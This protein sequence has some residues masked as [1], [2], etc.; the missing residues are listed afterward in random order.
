M[1]L[2]GQ[3]G[4]EHVAFTVPDLE[5]AVQFFVN[6]LG[7]EH[8][9]DIGPFR[10]PD[11][12]WFSDNLNLDPRAEIPR[13]C[14]LRCGNGSNFELFEYEAPEQRQSWPQMSDWGGFHLA[15]YVDDMDAALTYLSDE[16]VRILGGAKPGMGVEAGEK[17]TFAHFLTPWGQLLE[18]VSFP[19]GKQY[20]EGRDRLLWHPI[21][22]EVTP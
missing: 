17:S 19:N 3:R 13:A 5:E 6:V 8:F 11:G 1:S 22:Q 7:C 2:P 10:D 14:L 21:P 4:V 20:M 18:L 15:F 16:G 12:T 9:Y